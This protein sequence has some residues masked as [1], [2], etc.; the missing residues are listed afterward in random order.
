[1]EVKSLDRQNHV[2]AIS[3]E[4]K[5]QT[6]ARINKSNSSEQDL[7]DLELKIEP[8]R[9]QQMIQQDPTK[10]CGDTNDNCTDCGCKTVCSS[11]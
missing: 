8:K 7:F 11:C 2:T 3:E 10:Y 5:N 9:V 6:R 1:M 4:S